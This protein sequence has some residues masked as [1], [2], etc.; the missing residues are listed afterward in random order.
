MLKQCYASQLYD[1][2]SA[3]ITKALLIQMPQMSF[4]QFRNELVRVLG[5]PQRSGVKTSTKTVMTS[6]VVVEQNKQQE[7]TKSQ[8][9]RKEK[10]SA[11]S[12]QIKDLHTKLDQAVAENTQIKEF[13]SPMALQQA[14]MTILQVTQPSPN[15]MS[16]NQPEEKSFWASTGNLSYWLGWT[17]VRTQQNPAST[18]MIQGMKFR[19]ALGWL[20]GTSSLSTN[21]SNSNNN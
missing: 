20:P 5:T 4:T 21:S 9:K 3:S 18:A 19:I 8:G 11:Q 12:S 17:V 10:I 15:K 1:R 14:F 6:S 13:L 2:N 7:Q 16:R